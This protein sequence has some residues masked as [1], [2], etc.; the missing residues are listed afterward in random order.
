MQNAGA[1]KRNYKKRKFRVLIS[2]RM[3]KKH[4]Q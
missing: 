2:K 4:R 3:K 1:G